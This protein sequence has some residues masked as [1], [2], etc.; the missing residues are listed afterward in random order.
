MKTPVGT[1][2]QFIEPWTGSERDFEYIMDV[3][4]DPKTQRK[5]GAFYTP[6][7]YAKKATELVKKAIARV[8]D[9]NDYVIIDRCAGTGNLEMWLDDGGEDILSHV[10][11]S[12]YELKEWMVLKDRFNGRVRYII[13]PVPQNPDSLPDLDSDGFLSGAN[14]LTRDIIDNPVVRG[15]LDDPNCTI[16]LYENPPFV[17]TTSISYQNEGS[18]AKAS[19]W[20]KSDVVVAMK[21]EVS[22]AVSN[23][24]ANAFIW[25]AFKYFLRSSTD[26]YIVFSPIKYWK[27]QHLISKKFMG[28]FA[29]NRKHF[30]AKTAACV[31]CIYWSNEED[32]LTRKFDLE[33]YDINERHELVDEDIVTVKRIDSIFSDKYFDDRYFDDDVGNGILCG[34]NGKEKSDGHVIPIYNKNIVC[35]CSCHA[36]GFDNPRL[37]AQV[38]IATRYNGHGF[39]VRKDNF[40]LKL[41]LLVAARYTDNCNSWKVM[42]MVMKSGDKAEQYESDVAAGRLDVFLCRALIWT[43]LTHYSHMRSLDGSDGRFY[44]NELCFDDLDGKMTLARTA[45]DKFIASGYELTEEEEAL[46]GKWHQILDYVRRNC[47]NEYVPRYAYGLYQIDEE[48]NVKVEQGMKSDGSPNM[49]R[50]YGDLNNLIKDMKVMVKR[51]YLD[52]LVDTLFEY[53]F[54]K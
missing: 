48:I 32:K 26:S 53:E 3:L 9:G 34:L 43:G 47:A 22:G 10:I 35:Y 50:K 29:F 5:L 27:S 14:A 40:L 20:M 41:P 11:V 2:E 15:Y 36:S 1:L 33:A 49:V 37:T 18:A 8:P 6:P 13:P 54:L 30:H 24:M 19:D 44:R 51:Y 38:S 42:S 39:Y 17:E 25:S 21:E 28:G 16:I 31:S 45:L 46:F 23:D 12:T 52:N 7:V 4:N